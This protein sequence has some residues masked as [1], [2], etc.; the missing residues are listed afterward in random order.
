MTNE[1]LQMAWKLSTTYFPKEK[2]RRYLKFLSQ[3]HG[4][5]KVKCLEKQVRLN[6]KGYQRLLGV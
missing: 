5:I 1:K 3:D 2:F 6:E 4:M